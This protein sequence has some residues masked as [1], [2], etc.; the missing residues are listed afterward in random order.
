MSSALKH[1]KLKQPRT[2][3]NGIE[4]AR[5]K[6]ERERERKENLNPLFAFQFASASLTLAEDLLFVA[7]TPYVLDPE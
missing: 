5:R 4:R 3:D 1:V 2:P 7:E 6:R